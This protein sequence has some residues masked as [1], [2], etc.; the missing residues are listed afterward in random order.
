MGA[1]NVVRVDQP[2]VT[3]AG[4]VTNTVLRRNESRHALVGTDV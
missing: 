3:D 2:K 4:T 1:R